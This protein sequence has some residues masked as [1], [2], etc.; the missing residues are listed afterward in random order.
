MAERPL[1]PPPGKPV[2]SFNQPPRITHQE[3]VWV[4]R[5]DI[6]KTNYTQ[7]ERGVL[8][9]TI[10]G[11][12]EKLIAA[13]PTLYL[14]RE[15]VDPDNH[16]WSYRYWGKGETFTTESIGQKNLIPEKYRRLIRTVETDQPVDIDYTFPTGLT[17]DQSFIEKAQETIEEARLRIIS[18]IIDSSEEV[19]V[20]GETGE[21]GPMVINESIVDEG[22]AIDTGALVLDSKVTALGNGKAIKITVRYPTN[23]ADLELVDRSLGQKDLTPEKYKRLITTNTVRKIVGTSYVF[24]SSLSGD[25]AEITLQWDTIERARLRITEEVIESDDSLLTGQDFDQWGTL[26]ITETVVSEGAARDSGFLVKTSSVTPFGNGKAIKITISYPANLADLRL[27][28]QTHNKKWDVVI[29]YVER[30]IPAGTEIGLERAEITPIDVER[31]LVREYDYDELIRVLDSYIKP[32]PAS[33]DLDLPKVLHGISV[34]WDTTLG[35]GDSSETGTSFAAG[36]SGTVSLQLPNASQSSASVMPE[37]IPDIRGIPGKDLPATDYF[38]FVPESFTEAD[39]LARLTSLAGVSV[40][41]WPIF[42]TD[43]PTFILTGQKASVEAK[44][45]ARVSYSFSNSESGSGYSY[46][47]GAGNGG[48]KDFGSSVQAIKLQPTIHGVIELSGDLTKSREVHA[49]AEAE[50]TGFVGATATPRDEMAEVIG[51]VTPTT[52][53]STGGQTS[54]PTSGVRL[55]TKNVDPFEEFGGYSI[56]RARVFDFGVLA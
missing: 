42:K 11:G 33:V 52:L 53:P 10:P 3:Q 48:S 16:P 22:S 51:S 32:F 38:F 7:L 47:S 49:Y 46:A 28:G 8:Y 56:V 15:I 35:E 17:G 9:N 2:R 43:E 5:V 21:Y 40:T 6:T 55:K 41:A 44:A 34:V 20:G 27:H 23:L 14:L 12:D 50:I 19:L 36:T 29:P 4:E 30:I 39:I 24:P 1:I 13:H 54:I 18:E 26:T 37:I 45:S 31:S 25:E